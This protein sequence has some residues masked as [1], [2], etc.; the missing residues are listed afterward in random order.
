LEDIDAGRVNCV[1]VYN[2]DRLSR[3]L[4]DF[5]RLME[6]FDRHAVSFVAVTQQLNTTTSLCRLTLD[7]LLSFAQFEQEIIGE[8]T[9][10]KMQAARRKGKW[11]GGIPVLGYDLATEG[12][13][14]VVNEKEAE[15][16]VRGLS[17]SLQ[18][19]SLSRRTTG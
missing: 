7:I 10:D 13:H 16:A 12:G 5:A 3:S 9:R 1:V 4:L 6:G 8:R 2:V 15:Q 11:I 19:G 14:L 18:H 17:H